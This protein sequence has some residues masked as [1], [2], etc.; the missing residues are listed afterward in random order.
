MVAAC[1]R[2]GAHFSIITRIDRKIRR[3]IAAISEEAWTAIRAQIAEIAYTAFASDRKHRVTGRLVVR[4]VRDLAVGRQGELFLAWRYHTVFTD[5]PFTLV[6]AEEQH[7]DHAV[8]KQTLADLIDGPL[9]SGRFTA[10]AAWLTLAA[11]PHTLTRAAG[12]LASVFHARAATIRRH[13][14]HIPARIARRG[15]GH[16]TVHLPAHWHAE[17]PWIGLFDATGHPATA[18]AG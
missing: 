6:Q 4:R 18:R 11:L 7:R 5:S 15:R 14:I 2:T 9:P 3:T 12:T 16:I 1:R 13:L 8:I 17:H 10:N